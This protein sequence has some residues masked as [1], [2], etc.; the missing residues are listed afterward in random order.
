MRK[1]TRGIK[2]LKTILNQELLDGEHIFILRRDEV[3]TSK[4][5]MHEHTLEDIYEFYSPK[6]WVTS[7]WHEDGLCIIIK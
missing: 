5:I 1:E 7:F 6:D 4:G 2:Q 3:N